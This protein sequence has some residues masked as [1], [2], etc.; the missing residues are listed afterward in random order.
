ML[1]PIH[2]Q[3]G[4]E[5]RYDCPQPVPMI[6]L[7]NMHFSRAA[8]IVIPD[9][10]TTEP[11]VPVTAYRDSFGNWC[12]RLIAPVGEHGRVRLPDGVGESRL[13]RRWARPGWDRVSLG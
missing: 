9:L 6:L 13:P 7:V 4:F 10:L 5:L 12:S 3:V 2:L 11:F 1:R 8:D